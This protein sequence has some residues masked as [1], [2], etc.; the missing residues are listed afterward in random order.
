MS[1]PDNKY[2]PECTRYE[3]ETYEETMAF[4]K[5]Y[6]FSG[7]SGIPSSSGEFPYDYHIHCFTDKPILTK[8]EAKERKILAVLEIIKTKTSEEASEYLVDRWDTI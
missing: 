7:C 3:G 1:R 8:T 5:K 4:Y 2:C 6:G